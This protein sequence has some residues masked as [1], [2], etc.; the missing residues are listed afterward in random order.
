MTETK[1]D[2]NSVKEYFENLKSKKQTVQGIELEQVYDNCL[3]LLNKYNITGQKDAMRKLLFHMESLEREKE[4]IA[5]G[6][7]T[8]VY[9]DDIKE[10]IEKVP[11][12]VVKII[13]LERYER[14]IPDEVMEAFIKVKDVFNEFF[15]VFTDYTREHEKK[16]IK[17]TDPILFGMFK[18]QKTASIV[19]RMYYIGDW[20]DEFCDLTLDKM[21]SE[22]K[23]VSSRNI[24]RTIKYPKDIEELRQQ[25]AATERNE[26]DRFTVRSQPKENRKK[27]FFKKVKAFFS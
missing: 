18:D 8:F 4:A 11:N 5:A 15:V 27:S 1:K 23:D 12:R 17:E 26:V 25:L 19:E 3:T 7:D 9:L 2:F 20:E 10:Y 14:E 6:I 21:I 24:E 13:E 22:M 16:H